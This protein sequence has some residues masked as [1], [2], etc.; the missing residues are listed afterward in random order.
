M[1][2]EGIA[3]EGQPQLRQRRRP[4]MA[5]VRHRLQIGDGQMA[6]A[7]GGIRR[8]ADRGR[9]GRPHGRRAHR[10]GGDMVLGLR[11]ARAQLFSQA[12]AGRGCGTKCPGEPKREV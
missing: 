6:F 7:V 12:L 1:H 11:N 5:A 2:L 9:I 10:I 3:G 4:L 8:R